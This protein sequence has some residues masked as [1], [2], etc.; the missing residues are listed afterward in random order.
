MVLAQH[1]V[2][3]KHWILLDSQSTISIFT[4]KH[5][6]HN[7]SKCDIENTI[8]CYCNGRYQ[9]ID[10]EGTLPGFGKVYYNPESIA[11]ILSLAEVT[12]KF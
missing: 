11:N 10:Q 3:N 7:I 8:R 6:L 12:K 2:L 4:S 9:D 1:G 5:L